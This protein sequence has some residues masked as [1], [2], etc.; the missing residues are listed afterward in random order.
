[1]AVSGETVVVGALADDDGGGNSGS[2]YVYKLTPNSFQGTLTGKAFCLNSSGTGQ[3]IPVKRIT[4]V[5]VD[6]LQSPL[7]TAVVRLDGFSDPFTLTG[8]ALLK[9]PKSG[10]LQ[11]FGTDGGSTELALSGTIKL[12]KKTREWASLKGEIQ[13]LLAGTHCTFAGKFTAK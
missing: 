13:L 10:V 8:M 4:T 2:A 12:N 9:N 3:K 6:T 1:V 5:S 7:I 11:L